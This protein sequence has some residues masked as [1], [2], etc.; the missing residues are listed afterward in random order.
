[1][2]ISGAEDLGIRKRFLQQLREF[3][4][5][6]RQ[7]RL[8]R[9]MA[10]VESGSDRLFVA[11][12]GARGVH[13][14][15]LGKRQYRLIQGENGESL[16]SPVGL[17]AG[18][19]GETYVVDSLL[20]EIYII[21]SGATEAK[22][23]PLQALLS[24]PTGLA[25]HR[26]SGRIFVVDTGSHEVKVFSRDGKLLRR[27]GGRGTAP[28]KFNYPTMIW[29]S[30]GGELLVSDTLNFRTQVFDVE[31]NFLRQFGSPGDRA[32]FQSQSKGIASDAHGNVYIVD[33]MQH[34]VQIFDSSGRFLYRLGLRGESV[35]EFWLPS[36]IFIGERETIYVADSY[37]SRIQVFR[38]TGG[39]SQ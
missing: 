21:E 30:Y 33:S 17:A 8:I 16:P 20:A 29:M 24:Q 38:Y 36:G 32:G 1:M 5:G 31:G 10:V 6:P 19:S 25:F 22:R 39:S 4:S 27:I 11:D 26:P 34:A 18:L 3:V 2:S 14:F 13:L 28:G 12:P 7:E 23:V 37:N 35:G 15:D 9:P